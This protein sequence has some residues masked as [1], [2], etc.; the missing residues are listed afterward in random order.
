MTS[1]T[2]DNDVAALVHDHGRMVESKA[3]K[4]QALVGMLA[5][6]S[7]ALTWWVIGLI[8]RRQARWM[9]EQAAWYRGFAA[10]IDAR[11]RVAPLDPDWAMNDRLRG[12]EDKLADLHGMVNKLGGTRSREMQAQLRAAVEALRDA[13]SDL[14]GAIQAYEADRSAIVLRPSPVSAAASAQ[15][16]DDAVCRMLA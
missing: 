10:E 12:L 9:Q 15:E 7:G 2:M 8:Y 6:L 3:G 5:Y 13:V 14:R 11:D 1:I 4:A 16:F